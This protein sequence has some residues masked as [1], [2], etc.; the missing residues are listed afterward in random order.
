MLASAS[1][2]GNSLAFFRPERPAG[3]IIAEAR[4]ARV[5][6]RTHFDP[7]PGGASKSEASGNCNLPAFTA[8]DPG[9]QGAGVK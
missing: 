5:C 2:P 8:G 4:K 6:F 1:I 7:G 9:R 3:S